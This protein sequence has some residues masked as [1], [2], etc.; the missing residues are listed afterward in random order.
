MDYKDGVKPIVLNNDLSTTIQADLDE[1]TVT[2]MLVYNN[3]PNISAADK[4]ISEGRMYYIVLSTA[5]TSKSEFI[6]FIEQG[7]GD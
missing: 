2:V 5:E 3:D 4:T 1:G 6:E 7:W